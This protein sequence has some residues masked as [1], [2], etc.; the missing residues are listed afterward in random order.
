MK[1]PLILA[2]SKGS[3]ENPS[4]ISTIEITEHLESHTGFEVSLVCEW[5]TDG[6]PHLEE[7]YLSGYIKWDGCA[8]IDFPDDYLHFCNLGG[9]ELHCEIMQATY[10]YV[11]QFRK[12][13]AMPMYSRAN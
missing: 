10:K 9:V 7:S 5:N 11:I 1:I 12:D 6:S 8:N 3:L 4:I 13:N 2:I